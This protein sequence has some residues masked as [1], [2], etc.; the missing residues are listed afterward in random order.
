MHGGEPM[1]ASTLTKVG[2]RELTKRVYDPK[3]LILL[4]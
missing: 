3:L 1:G 4:G 2:G